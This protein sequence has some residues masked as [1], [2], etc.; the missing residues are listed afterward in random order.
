[1]ATRPKEQLLKSANKMYHYQ[2]KKVQYLI[3]WKNFIYQKAYEG[4]YLVFLFTNM[5][6]PNYYMGGLNV[7]RTNS[8]TQD[9]NS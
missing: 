7:A 4:S 6:C 1:M 8:G 5:T 9:T 3:G 2:F